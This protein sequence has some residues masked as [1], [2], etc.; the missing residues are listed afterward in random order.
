MTLRLFA[1]VLLG[2]L[3]LSAFAADP[4]TTITLAADVRASSQP[5]KHFWSKISAAGPASQAL[6]ATWL[7]QWHI[8]VAECG[9]GY[10][11]LTGVF[12]PD[13]F[14]YR[15]DKGE[16]VYNFQYLDDLLDRILALD[17]HPFFQLNFPPS[18]LASGKTAELMARFVR[19]YDDRYGSPELRKWYFEV[20]QG[21]GTN[22]LELYR[23]TAAAIKGIDSALKVGGPAAAAGDEVQPADLLSFAQTRGAALDFVSDHYF[24][25]AGASA[26][27]TR[28]HL[29]QLRALVNGSGFPKAEIHVTEWS[30][31]ASPRDFVHDSL[32]AAAWILRSNLESRDLVDSLAYQSFTDQ[33]E[34]ADGGRGIFHGGCGLINYQGIVKPAFHAYRYLNALGD[35]VLQAVPG[36]IISRRKNSGRVV[37]LAYNYPADQKTTLPVCANLAA[38]DQLTGQGAVRTLSISLSG[39]RPGGQ[40]LIEMLQSNHGNA[41]DAWEQ[42]RSPAEPSRPAIVNL[43]SGAR[44]MRIEYRNADD[45]GR[46]ALSRDLDPWA[47]LLLREL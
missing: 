38:A 14:L 2:A 26:D 19:H 17:A 31:S 29:R 4:D 5:L 8:G 21:G 20:G 47:V 41:V 10:V 35:E 44:E 11:R 39:L 42:M 16:E 46:F 40:I 18:A 36:G 1:L 28:D 24:P 33:A 37:L 6:R 3:G 27:A 9:F 43:Q 22:Y 30:S 34:D 23:A 45:I 7:D 12:D 32:P 15:Q 13:L 25:P